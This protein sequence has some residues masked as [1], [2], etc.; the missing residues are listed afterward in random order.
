MRHEPSGFDRFRIEA[1]AIR[2]ILMIAPSRLEAILPAPDFRAFI[3]PPPR[4]SRLIER[5]FVDGLLTPENSRH[6]WN[7]MA[8]SGCRHVILWLVA[9]SG[10]R[11]RCDMAMNGI[12][13][14]ED[15]AIAAKV[16]EALANERFGNEARIDRVEVRPDDDPEYPAIWL[17]V[18]VETP[19]E[20]LLDIDAALGFHRDLSPALEEKGIYAFPI[21]SFVSYAEI[22]DAA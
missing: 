15:C 17:R 21:P 12:P 13:T 2:R 6:I 22:G 9:R 3:F 18:V 1:G 8:S 16:A 10:K 5:K 7:A 14:A 4:S 20:A 19:G 11:D